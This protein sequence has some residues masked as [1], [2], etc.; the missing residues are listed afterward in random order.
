MPDSLVRANDWYCLQYLHQE[1]E[2]TLLRRVL[3]A[4]FAALA[5]LELS[6][7]AVH[8]AAFV[9]DIRHRGKEVSE[10]VRLEAALALELARLGEEELVRGTFRHLQRWQAR[11]QR[12][13]SAKAAKH[14]RFQCLLEVG[15]NL[16]QLFRPPAR[17]AAATAA[18]PKQA[19][20]RAAAAREAPDADHD[21]RDDS[22]EEGPHLAVVLLPYG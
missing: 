6:V 8:V 18:V 9:H 19:E 10:L 13:P 5:V 3:V 12:H 16:E 20:T 7:L 17:L 11:G 14:V 22:L 2:Q 15:H 1:D 21:G 4:S